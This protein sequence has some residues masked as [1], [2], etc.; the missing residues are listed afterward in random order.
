MIRL[1]PTAN[2]RFRFAKCN[3]SNNFVSIY[4]YDGQDR[5]WGPPSLL[6]NGYRVSFPG[7][8]RPGRGVNKPPPSSAKVKERVEL[9]PYSQQF[10]QTSEYE[11]MLSLANSG[12]QIQNPVRP[13]RNTILIFTFRKTSDLHYPGLTFILLAAT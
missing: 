1:I 5:P 9:Y 6:H 11:A 12:N 2:R 8:K 4:T 10:H 7:V 3:P 13:Q